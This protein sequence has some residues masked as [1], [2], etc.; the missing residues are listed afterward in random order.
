MEIIFAKIENNIVVNVIIA[1]QEYIDAKPKTE[2]WIQTWADA[3]GEA[4]KKYNYAT[5]N[6]NYDS[7]N[8]AFINDSP[9]PSWKLNRLF[10][11]EAPVPY[12][13]DGNIYLWNEADCLWVALEPVP[14]NV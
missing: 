7:T 14:K 13:N 5:I 8:D 1:S 12:P 3:N 9:Y 6:G 10:A 2:K 11:W 4:A